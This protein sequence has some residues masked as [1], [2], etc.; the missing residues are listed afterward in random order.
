M[1]QTYN[2]SFRAYAFVLLC[3]DAVQPDAAAPTAVLQRQCLHVLYQAAREVSLPAARQRAA[4]AAFSK[5]LVCA[6]SN[7]CCNSQAK[8]QLPST[9]D[10][11]EAQQLPKEALNLFLSRALTMYRLKWY[12][13]FTANVVLL[14]LQVS[15]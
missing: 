7:T 3:M 12:C 6:E 10:P 4:A 15:S 13:H 11:G 2:K 8:Q 5:Q 1:W 14:V 9:I